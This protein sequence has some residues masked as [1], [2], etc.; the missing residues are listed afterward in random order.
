MRTARLICLTLAL[1][2]GCEWH[3]RT[4]PGTNQPP[5]A[6]LTAPAAPLRPKEFQDTIQLLRSEV[7]RIVVALSQPNAAVPE[8]LG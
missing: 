3:R 6:T 5:T 8:R 7:Q 1:F 2:A 4:D